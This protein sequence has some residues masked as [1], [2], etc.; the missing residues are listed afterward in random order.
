MSGPNILRK[1]PKTLKLIFCNFKKV[2]KTPT[3]QNFNPNN[4]EL[5][6]RVGVHLG[7]NKIKEKSVQPTVC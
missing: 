7:H 4:L 2:E 1:N 3:S 5:Y 6:M